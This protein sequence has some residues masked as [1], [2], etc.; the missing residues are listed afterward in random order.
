MENITVVEDK[1]KQDKNGADFANVKLSDGRYVNLMFDNFAAYDGP[2]DYEAEITKNGK[3]W[4]VTPGSLK[5]ADGSKPTEKTK[6]APK[7]I[8]KVYNVPAQSS[9]RYDYDRGKLVNTCIMSAAQIYQGKPEAAA[10]GNPAVV[11]QVAEQ[12]LSWAE[13]KMKSTEQSAKDMA[14]NVPF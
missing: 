6:E 10:L 3:F 12:L 8:S 9:N 11:I 5:A 1:I 13:K 7:V 2:G 14:D 4:N